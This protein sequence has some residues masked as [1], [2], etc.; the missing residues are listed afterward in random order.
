M[1]ANLS[2]GL[3]FN[4]PEDI[5]KIDE[6]L[7]SLFNEGRF[8][9]AVVVGIDNH[10][11]KRSDELIPWNNPEYGGGEGDAYVDFITLTLKPWIDANYLTL[12]DAQNTAIAGSSLGGLISL[13]AGCKYPE[14]FG[15]L[16]IFSPAFWVVKAEIRQ[17]IMSHP[18][19]RQTRVYMDVGTNEG[20]D[21]SQ[22]NAYLK[23]A[24][25]IKD[26]L[27]KTS[28]PKDNLKLVIDE[29]ARHH[30]NY[31]AKRFPDA[32]LWLFQ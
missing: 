16:A 29:G 4:S 18:L 11:R 24:E 25:E 8:N 27:A 15:K 5:S 1:R 26:L 2:R 7:E 17:Y 20:N 21:N 19:L 3:V 10:P 22:R 14:V 23:D 30:E 13:Y 9:G 12:T 32:L 31:W 6:S 28:T